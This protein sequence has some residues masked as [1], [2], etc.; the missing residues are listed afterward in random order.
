[1]M[2]LGSFSS[3]FIIPAIAT[4]SYTIST[5]NNSFDTD[6]NPLI[7]LLDSHGMSLILSTA[8]LSFFI[9]YGGSAGF[10]TMI[11][12]F[13]AILP[14]FFDGAMAYMS[15]SR[16]RVLSASPSVE[17]VVEGSGDEDEFKK[18]SDET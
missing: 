5:I 17:E 18:Q 12:V 2:M 13:V 11:C 7:G 4:A 3:T 9:N 8:L 6:I 10:L 16:G 15:V 14:F 1:M